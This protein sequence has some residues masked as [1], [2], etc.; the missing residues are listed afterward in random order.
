MNLFT[1]T[2]LSWHDQFGRTDLPWRQTTDPYRIWISEIILQQTRVAQGYDYYL[3][4]IEHFPRVEDLAAASEDE[5]LRLW[6]G[7]GYYSRARNLHAA[8]KSIVK[9]GRF[10]DDYAGVRQLKG[11]GDYTAAAICSIA[12][13]LPYAVVDGNVYRV[14]ARYFGMDVPIDTT[15]GKKQF[16]ALATEL[17]DRHRPGLY[18]SAIMDFG[19]L[20]C[21]PTSPS[22]QDCPLQGSCMACRQQL[23]EKLPVKARRTA[24]AERFFVYLL[25][26]NGESLLLH[27]RSA[28]DIWKGLYEPLLFEFTKAPSE[29]EILA[30]FADRLPGFP[31]VFSAE[32]YALKHV[33]THRMLHLVFY[34]VKATA[35]ASKCIPMENDQWVRHDDLDNHAMPKAVLKALSHF[36]V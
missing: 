10:P 35:A 23:T 8:A 15:E 7:L 24:I 18:N 16:A 28:K 17:L 19:A 4:F 33:L 30:A 25:V 34:S 26:D 20:Q 5:V 22:C 3:R 29:Q 12:Y 31:L 32:P 6:Q 14:L 2:I 27:R 21:K 1:R 13:Q 36:S 11:V 9:A